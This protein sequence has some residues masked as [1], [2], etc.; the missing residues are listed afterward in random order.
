MKK[1]SLIYTL[2]LIFS[3]AVFSACTQETQNRIGRSIQNWTGVNG[4][5]EIYSG[6]KLVKRFIKIDKLS[7]ASGT[8]ERT[9]RPYRFGYG[10]LDANLNGKADP[11]ENKVYFEFSDYSTNYVFFEDPNTKK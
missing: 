9:Q 4:V 5:L 1:N 11:D 3:L 8:K 6:G 2:I 10:V 7:T